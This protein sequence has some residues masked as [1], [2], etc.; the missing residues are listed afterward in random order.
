LFALH[1]LISLKE[2]AV[3]Q[4]KH[5]LLARKLKVCKGLMR[6]DWNGIYGLPGGI[7]PVERGRIRLV[8]F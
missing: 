2:K 5:C 3:K 4:K 8:G 6:E 1:L 7:P